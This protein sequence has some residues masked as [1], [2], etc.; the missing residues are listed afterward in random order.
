MQIFPTRVHFKFETGKGERIY[1]FSFVPDDGSSATAG[2][3]F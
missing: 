1:R 2:N 3:I